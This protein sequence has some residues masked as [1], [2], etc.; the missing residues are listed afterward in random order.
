MMEVVKYVVRLVLLNISLVSLHEEDKDSSFLNVLE[1]D[2][3]FVLLG[4]EV[5]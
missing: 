1:V 4:S 5:D 3:D 2:S